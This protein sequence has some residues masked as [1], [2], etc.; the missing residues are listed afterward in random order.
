M[1]MLSPML[2]GNSFIRPLQ[3]NA[4]IHAYFCVK[5]RDGALRCALPQSRKVGSSVHLRSNGPPAR[6]SCTQ[7]LAIT[8]HDLSRAKQHQT[9]IMKSGDCD[10]FFLPIHLS[11]TSKHHHHT[12]QDHASSLKKGASNPHRQELAH[13]DAFKKKC[14]LRTPYLHPRCSI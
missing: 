8:C 2:V 10:N 5:L 12:H 7:L 1:S 14:F 6:T 9:F 11:L 4:H 3:H 13:Q